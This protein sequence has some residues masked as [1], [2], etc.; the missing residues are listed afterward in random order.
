[1][2]SIFEAGDDP[3]SESELL[4]VRQNASLRLSVWKRRSIYSA[5]GLVLSC[6]SVAPFSE[7]YSLHAYAEPF[8]RILVYL[9][10]GLLV[11]FVYCCALMLGAWNAFR[12]LG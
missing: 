6:T 8:G 11:V 5:I 3:R 1:M 12:D 9:S 2:N 10:M 7:G 4:A